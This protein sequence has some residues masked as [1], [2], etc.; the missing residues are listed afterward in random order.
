MTAADDEWLAG[1]FVSAHDYRDQAAL[2]RLNGHYQRSFTFD[3]LDA[4]IWRRVYAFRQRAFKSSKSYLQLSEARTL[5][6]QDAGFGS[7]EALARALTTG[8]SPVPPYAIDPQDNHVAP[9]RRLTDGEW[10]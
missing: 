1:D 2:Q 5:I 6:A 3:D 8:A 4:E 10:D 7:W 9:R